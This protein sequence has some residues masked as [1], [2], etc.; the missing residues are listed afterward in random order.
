MDTVDPVPMTWYQRNKTQVK[1]LQF[2]IY[3]M[4]K[5][6]IRIAPSVL[7]VPEPGLVIRKPGVLLRFD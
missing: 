6:G 5:E 7:P 2:L 4:R 3:H 1:L